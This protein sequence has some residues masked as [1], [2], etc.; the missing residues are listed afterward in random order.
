MPL[1][2]SNSRAKA[3][4]S[5]TGSF[6]STC[7]FK[8]SLMAPTPPTPSKLVQVIKGQ[9]ESYVV[10]VSACI[11]PS[12][13]FPTPPRSTSNPTAQYRVDLRPDGT[14]AAVKLTRTSGNPNFD[15]AV[16]T[17]IRRCS[18]IPTPPSGKNPAY[19]DVNYSMYD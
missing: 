10:K 18:P 7:S 11:K 17:G 13:A 8:R 19:I 3:S 4:Q 12:V 9:S 14:I 5:L 2:L 15:R 6:R 1:R 16:D